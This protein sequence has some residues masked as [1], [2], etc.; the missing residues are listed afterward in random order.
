MSA[1]HQAAAIRRSGGFR[2]LVRCGVLLGVL[3]VLAER[4]FAAS[5]T[6]AWDPVVSPVSASGYVLYYGP[7]AGDYTTA[8]DVGDAAIR[9]VSGLA[10]G[11]TYHFAVTAY[12]SLRAQSGYSNDVGVTLA[13]SVPMAS[14]TAS[15]TSGTV[16]LALNFINGSTG[17]ISAY[18]WSF[19]DGTASS[20]PSP[21][22]MYGVPGAYTVSLT[23]TGSGG[24]NTQTRSNY[25]VVSASAAPGDGALGGSY[26]ES[27][28]AVDFSAVGTRDWVRWPGGE[29]K[30]TGGGQIAN[31]QMVGASTASSANTGTRLLSWQ[32]GSPTATGATTEAVRAYGPG[33]GFLFTAPAGTEWRTL[34]V[35]A[36]AEIATGKLTAQLSDGSAPDFV[37]TPVT[38]R[39]SRSHDIVYTLRY[40]AASS[41]QTLTVTWTQAGTGDASGRRGGGPGSVRLQGAALQ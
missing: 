40:R 12:D 39:T 10:E 29:R 3:L 33:G 6:V 30:A 5:V 13:Y 16:P 26:V 4:P 37:S 14:F 7:A 35:Y 28:S 36:G 32:D 19:G 18:A 20:A 25:V 34:V 22:K 17:T 2:I 38:M 11:A 21:A 31:F 15:T 9:T 1:T 24:S 27:S 23:V 41:G 8:I